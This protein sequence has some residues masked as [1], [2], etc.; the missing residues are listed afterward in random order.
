MSSIIVR[1]F[2]ETEKKMPVKLALSVQ[3]SKLKYEVVSE[4]EHHVNFVF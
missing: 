2:N 3:I 4:A 1:I